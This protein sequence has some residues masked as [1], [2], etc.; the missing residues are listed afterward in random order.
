MQTALQQYQQTNPTAVCTWRSFK[1]LLP[2]FYLCAKWEY[3]DLPLSTKHSGC[4]VC[5]VFI[6]SPDCVS[7]TCCLKHLHAWTTASNFKQ[8]WWLMFN[9]AGT[10]DIAGKRSMYRQLCEPHNS[11]IGGRW[12][13]RST[14]PA[15]FALP[16]MSSFAFASF[17]KMCQQQQQEWLWIGFSLIDGE[18]GCLLLKGRLMLMRW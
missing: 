11:R 16:K 5:E 14:P 9:S 7:P 2:A 8:R 1:Y 17:M 18:Q 13:R 3:S 6:A 15:K 10:V 12:G 4:G